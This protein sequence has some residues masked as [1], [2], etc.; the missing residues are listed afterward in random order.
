VGTTGLEAKAPGEAFTLGFGQDDQVHVERK[1]MKQEEG[2]SHGIFDINKG[3]RLYRWVTTVANYHVGP[4]VVEVREQLPR[5]RQQNIEVT[6]GDMTPQP[7]DE[8][9]DKPGLKVWKLTLGPK[10]KAKVDFGY[11]VKYPSG[12]QVAG[13]E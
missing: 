13:L 2:D 9:P 1:A 5:S 8:D 4:R 3:E 6:A 12:T 7:S 11:R 10:E